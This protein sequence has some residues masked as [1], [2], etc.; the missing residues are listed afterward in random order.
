MQEDWNPPTLQPGILLRLPKD[1]CQQ[2]QAKR[3]ASGFA[4][5]GQHQQNPL[6]KTPERQRQRTKNSIR[7][8]SIHDVLLMVGEKHQVLQ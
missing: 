7:A 6:A 4:A 3:I 2:V 8:S 1:M 5:L